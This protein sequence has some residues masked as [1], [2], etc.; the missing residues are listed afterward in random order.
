M[1]GGRGLKQPRWSPPLAR[2][3]SRHPRNVYNRREGQRF[4]EAM[5]KL[6][7]ALEIDPGFPRARS[8]L[9][10]LHSLSPT[11]IGELPETAQAAA[12]RHAR[13]AIERDPTMAEPHAVLAYL[14]QQRRE[15]ADAYDAYELALELNADDLTTIPSSHGWGCRSGR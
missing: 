13:L 15:F 11:Y 1:V 14:F 7:R 12:Q 4:V 10:A 6:D 9:A 5:A 2:W 8:S 3:N